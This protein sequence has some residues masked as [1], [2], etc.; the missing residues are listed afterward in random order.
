MCLPSRR[1]GKSRW[2]NRGP[3]TTLPALAGAA[4]RSV[5]RHEYRHA[6]LASMP[7]ERGAPR[8]RGCASN[9]IA[10]GTGVA[11]LRGRPSPLSNPEF[12]S[13]LRAGIELRR[14]LRHA[15]EQVQP[16]AA[17]QPLGPPDFRAALL[18]R[19]R[20]EAERPR[21][22]RVL[23]VGCGAGRFAEVAL[24]AGAE[25]V[26]L[27]YSNAVDACYA[28]LGHHENLLVV[29]GDIYALPFA[30]GEFP[31]VYS[32]GRLA[33]HARCR[34]R[35]SRPCRRWSAPAERLCVDFYERSWKSSLLPKYWLRPLTKRMPKPRL[36]AVLQTVV[37]KLLPVS[38]AMGKVPEDRRTAEA[39][40][41]RRELRG[42][43]A[44]R[45]A[46]AARVVV[47][48]H[49]RLACS[50]PTISRK[51]PPPFAVGWS[52]PAWSEIEVLK[53]RT[54]RWPRDRRHPADGVSSSV[55]MRRAIAPAGRKRICAES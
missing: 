39:V 3:L 13:A 21:R 37:P 50:R 1:P 26:A 17:R 36:F 45:R 49:V 55:S 33:A 47:A 19:D 24:A 52:T 12:R 34:A 14:Q 51:P 18:E 46:A 23:D 22:R 38:R 11:R 32:L 9:G 44:A 2:K 48:R 16:H 5:S 40:G 42:R 30:K 15:M 25:V 7:E 54:S 53:G 4:L 27:D 20:L 29:Q 41:P 6:W 8:A 10:S 35:R 28:N 31:F 43:V